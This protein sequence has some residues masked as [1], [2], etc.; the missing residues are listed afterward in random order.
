M[1]PDVVKVPPVIGDVVATDVT[2]PEL[3]AVITPALAVIV[4]LSTLTTPNNELLPLA[5]VI[6]PA[7]SVMIVPSG[8]THPSW[9]FV[10]VVQLSTPEPLIVVVEPSPCRRP[11]ADEDPR[12]RYA[13][14]ITEPCQTPDAT[15]PR[16]VNAPP[17][18][19]VSIPPL[20]FWKV[21]VNPLKEEGLT[22]FSST[23]LAF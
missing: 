18:E 6:A 8:S 1:V 21:K 19:K 3:T 20:V 5:T 14:P 12:G 17:T 13:D 22:K 15:V 7:V 2:V 4:V 9:E 11:R 10:A 16:A 23:W